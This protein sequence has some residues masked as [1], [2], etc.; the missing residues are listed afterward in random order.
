MSMPTCLFLFTHEVD[1]GH[2]SLSSERAQYE[3]QARLVVK[4]G[5]LLKAGKLIRA[6]KQRFLRTQAEV[7]THAALVSGNASLKKLQKNRNT[8]SHT[9]N[10]TLRFVRILDCSDSKKRHYKLVYSKV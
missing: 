9:H 8:H 4:S 7:H 2:R 10:H 5:W 6:P 3:G 1:L